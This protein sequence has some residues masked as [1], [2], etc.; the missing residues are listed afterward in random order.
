MGSRDVPSN[1]IQLTN[2]RLAAVVGVLCYHHSEGIFKM[3]GEI[4]TP[5]SR[6]FCLAVRMQYLVLAVAFINVIR[7]QK[8]V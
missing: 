5:N 2:P 6:N 4:G 7:R 1:A 8:F 3:G